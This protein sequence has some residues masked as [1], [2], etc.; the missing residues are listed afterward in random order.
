MVTEATSLTRGQN[1]ATAAPSGSG[2]TTDQHQADR[3][4]QQW[5]MVEKDLSTSEDVRKLTPLE[6]KRLNKEQL[7][8]ALRTLIN[9]PAEDTA[10]GPSVVQMGRI[11]AKLDDMLTKW[12]EEKEELHTQIKELKKDR[13]KMTEILSQHQRM[14]E[15]LEAERRAANIIM[16]GVPEENLEDAVTDVSKAKLVLST[17]GHQ[18]VPIKSVQRL[19]AAQRERRTPVGDSRPYRRPLKVVLANADDRQGVLESTNRLKNSDTAFRSIYI[20][21]D[22]HPLVRKELDRLRSVTKREKE[23]PENQGKDVSYDYK[24]RKVYVDDV[25]IDSFRNISF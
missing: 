23:R 14:L 18:N 17:I 20:K 10:A 15:S 9:E 8:F 19:G 5:S 7:Q 3:T 25:V 6:L 4:A 12:N 24:E 22:V 13:E 11:E 1:C 2:I 16:T 21:K